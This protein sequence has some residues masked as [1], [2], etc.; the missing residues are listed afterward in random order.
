MFFHAPL[1]AALALTP[2]AARDFRPVAVLSGRAVAIDGD[3]IA[4]GRVRVRLRGIAAPEDRPGHRDPGGP[5]ATASLARAVD[6]AW[7]V[8]LLDGSTA[9]GAR[10]PVGV[11][12]ARGVD[13]GAWQVRAGVARDC[14]GYS[15]GA[16]A[17]AEAAAGGHL[18]TIYA[19][20]DYCA[21]GN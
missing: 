12:L 3:D 10:R 19:L 11:C 17:D 2:P 4:F 14:P 16:Y 21:A 13:L 6:G 1:A 18:S 15:G 7:V 5:E 8:C 20:P 9:G